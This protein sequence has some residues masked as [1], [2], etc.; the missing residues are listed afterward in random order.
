MAQ[1]RR[2]GQLE[3]DW[4]LARLDHAWDQGLVAVGERRFGADPAR[5]NR[6]LR[7]ED[8]DRLR[9]PQ[10][11]LGHFVIS[12]AGCQADIPPDLEALTLEAFREQLRAA[13]VLAVVGKEDVGRAHVPG[14]VAA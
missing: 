4:P 6:L 10:R 2:L 14:S 13:L 8:H 12:L 3:H 7:P 1:L 9:G 11:G 5:G